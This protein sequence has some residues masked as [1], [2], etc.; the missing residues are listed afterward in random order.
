MK[1]ESARRKTFDVEFVEITPE[2]LDEVAEWCGGKVLGTDQK[3]SITVP[4]RN[5]KNV[6]QTEAYPGDRVVYHNDTRTY[7]KFGKKA[8][9]KTFEIVREQLVHKSAVDGKFVTAEDAADN[10]DTTIAQTVDIPVALDGVDPKTLG[11]TDLP[12]DAGL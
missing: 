7:K 8:F 5:A 4:D 1:I 12:R 3:R 6:H 2:N 9:E 10:P 11:T